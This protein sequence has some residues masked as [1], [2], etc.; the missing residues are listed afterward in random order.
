MR[1]ATAAQSREI[2]KISQEVY[3]LT[4]EILMESAGA[5]AAREINQS[6]FPELSRG[7]LAVVCGPGNNG[8]DGLV[9]A[10]HMHSMGY[11]DLIVFLAS[12]QK[13]SDL[14]Q[15]QLERAEKQGLKII[16]LQ[17]SPE[18]I[19]QIKSC[20]LIVDALFGIGLKRKITGELQK[21]MDVINSARVSV[22]SLDTPSGLDCDHGVVEG[23]V[24]KADM[25]ITFGLA[26]PGFFVY[27]GPEFVGKLRILPI[28][29]PL[30]ALRGVATSYF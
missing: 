3:G 20:E 30:E 9:V 21:L 29:F 13:L 27:D 17:K 25:T 24:I 19:D 1:L 2:D 16:D 18:K 11:R 15:L 10:R 26:K 28:G 6:Y 22:V 4:S 8:G 7:T 12:S 5:L 23:A 14:C